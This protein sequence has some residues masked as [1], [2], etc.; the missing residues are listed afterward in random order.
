MKYQDGDTE[1]YG[2]EKIGTML[3]QTKKSKNIMRAQ[4]VTKHEQII[5]EY[6]TIKSIYTPPSQLSG[7]FSKVMECVEMMAL[8]AI[9]KG[10]GGIGAQ[11][12][13]WATAVIDEESGDVM[14]L[15]KLLK[16][17]KYTEAWTLAAA[18]EYGRL[19]QGCG[20]NKYGIQRAV[21]TNACH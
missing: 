3:H 20:R 11:E 6:A 9:N 13:R 5:E 2:E 12:Y 1:E 19:F 14:N 4:T 16:H 17:P 10:F 8:A 7:G 15:K 18:N 21:G